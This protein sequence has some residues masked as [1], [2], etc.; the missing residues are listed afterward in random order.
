[1]SA[2]GAVW[3]KAARVSSRKRSPWAKVIARGAIPSG[4][5]GSLR[6]RCSRKNR[7]FGGVEAGARE[8]VK[9][10][11]PFFVKGHREQHREAKN[12]KH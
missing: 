2:A 10:V 5:G 8:N 3:P 1:M 7:S 4:G 11:E 12:Q 6:W 9:D